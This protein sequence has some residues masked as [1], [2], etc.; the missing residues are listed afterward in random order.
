[1]LALAQDACSCLE[2]AVIIVKLGACRAV[3]ASHCFCWCSVLKGDG[4]VSEEEQAVTVNYGWSPFNGA[5]GQV[6]KTS[7]T[8]VVS[9]TVPMVSSEAFCKSFSSIRASGSGL[10]R[11]KSLCSIGSACACVC[12]C[13]PYWGKLTWHSWQHMQL[14]CSL[15]VTW[16]IEQTCDSSSPSA[17]LAVVSPAA[18]SAW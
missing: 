1:M 6:H 14:V 2:K 8:S 16:A 5:N 7:R 10:V 13:S 11:F 15:L 9:S 18:C 4:D 3:K 12:V 17:C